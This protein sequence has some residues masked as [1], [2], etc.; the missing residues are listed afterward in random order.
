MVR[1]MP[2]KVRVAVAGLGAMGRQHVRVLAELDDV[3][4][5]AV[6]DPSPEARER[7][8]DHV[9]V[10]TVADWRELVDL[11]ADAVVNAMPTPV[12]H[13]VTLQ[14]LE[15]GKHVLVEK[16][17]AVTADEARDLVETAARL[18]RVL[19]VG[20]VERFNP[21]IRRLRD[22]V[23]DGGLGEIV[24]IACRRVGIARPVAPAS[25]V[26]V[27]LAIHDI[28]IC[29]YLLPNTQGRLVFASG[30]ALWG[31]QFEDHADLVLR[32]GD[33]VA[34]LQANWITPVKIRRLTVMGTEGLADVDYLEQTLRIYRGAPEAFGGPLWD[35][36]AVARE[37]SPEDVLIERGEPLRGEL[38]WFVER[39][40]AGDAGVEDARQAARALGI[41]L[42]ARSM[43]RGTSAP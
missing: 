41:A 37:S 21:A 15:A 19:V 35:F 24:T 27:D 14:L 22:I 12:H 17:I 9:V 3:E 30:R 42:E 32:F 8:T 40:R 18:E 25:D 33:A 11:G 39:V 2:K 43:I 1:G 23:A 10:P 16:P 7:V 4:I 6:A 34:V 31:N 36:F 26:I 5:V 29:G 38:E 28:D 20:H 13:E